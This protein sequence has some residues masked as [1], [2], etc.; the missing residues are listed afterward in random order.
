MAIDPRLPLPQQPQNTPIHSDFRRLLQRLDTVLRDLLTPDYVTTGNSV[1]IPNLNTS[2]TTTLSQA[3][4]YVTM[5]GLSYAGADV[6]SSVASLTISGN[7]VTA[8]R[9]GSTNKLTVYFNAHY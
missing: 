2:S 3:P 8:T 4:R 6:P 1:V 5:T 9:V 7:T